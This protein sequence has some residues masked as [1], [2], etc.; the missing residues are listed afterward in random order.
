MA[1]DLRLSGVRYD[2]L[3]CADEQDKRPTEQM[4]GTDVPL[5]SDFENSVLLASVHGG[6]RLLSMSAPKV[7]RS[8]SCLTSFGNS[9]Y[10]RQKRPLARCFRGA[11]CD[12]RRDRDDLFRQ[13]IQQSGRCILLK[14][15]IPQP[16]VEFS[17]PVPE[18]P[19]LGVGKALYSTLDVLDSSHG[20]IL[21]SCRSCP[22][23]LSAAAPPSRRE[24]EQSTEEKTSLQD[25][26]GVL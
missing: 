26:G 25:T 8:A 10:S 19:Q 20:C 1:T 11:E 15:G 22:T 3:G 4:L 21:R 12:P 9:A 16:C 18:L 7:A 6:C 14:L 17:K 23:A 5:H 24:T 2:P 13:V